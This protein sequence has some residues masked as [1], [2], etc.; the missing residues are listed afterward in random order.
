MT[1][2]VMIFTYISNK[3][4]ITNNQ[5]DNIKNKIGTALVIV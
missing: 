5:Q 4:K 2:N 3:N 1:Y